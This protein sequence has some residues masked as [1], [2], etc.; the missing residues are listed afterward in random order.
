MKLAVHPRTTLVFFF[1]HGL[2]VAPFA[3][4]ALP[5]SAYKPDQDAAPEA[6]VIAVLSVKSEVNKD[7]ESTRTHV[8]ARARVVEVNRTAS[9]LKVGDEIAIAYTNVE[10]KRDERRV[11]PGSYIPVLEEGKLV[12][13]YL[14]G[15]QKT[16]YRPAA[17]IY[18]FQ[19]IR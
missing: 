3:F 5:P 13:A 4:A 18:S 10:L 11:G 14:S 6:L 7:R 12:P 1:A 8:E 19:E 16:G 15:N 9:G 2:M 17:R